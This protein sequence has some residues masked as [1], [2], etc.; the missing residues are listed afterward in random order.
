MRVMRWAALVAILMT[1]A[2]CRTEPSIRN[3]ETGVL[4]WKVPPSRYVHHVSEPIDTD[5]ADAYIDEMVRQGWDVAEVEDAGAELP[6]KVIVV[7]R[8]L[9]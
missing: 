8:R 7:C 2:A 1:P 5:L 3:A 4:A 6:A 9:Q